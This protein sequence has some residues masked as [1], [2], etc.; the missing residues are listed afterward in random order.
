MEKRI[1]ISY[2]RS[3][4][5]G[6]ARAVCNK[7]TEQFG[8]DQVF[9]DV[10]TIEPGVDFVKQIEEAVG[11]CSVLLALVGERWSTERLQDPL[12][13]VRLEIA[14][15][16]KRD[17]RV[18]PVLVDDAVMPAA[19]DLPNDLAPITR[20]HGLPLSH[21]RF[22]GDMERVIDCVGRVVAPQQPRAT[23]PA[24]TN[25]APLPRRRRWSAAL[26]VLAL[27][28]VAGFAAGSSFGSLTIAMIVWGLGLVLT[29]CVWLG[30]P[31]R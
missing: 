5:A 23:T 30:K 6:Y 19:A 3:D 18:V 2:R 31:R 11:R 1:F 8:P 20:R 29:V 17:I 14:S 16:L 15:A 12:D 28:A 21:A 26:V 13:Y 25:A 10:D 22:N 27:T 24:D 4:T 9:M 7:L